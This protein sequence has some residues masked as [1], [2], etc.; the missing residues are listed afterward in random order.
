MV[1]EITGELPWLNFVEDGNFLH[2]SF[3]LNIF[4]PYV[5][6]SNSN[7]MCHVYDHCKC[8]VKN[9]QQ[10]LTD[11]SYRIFSNWGLQL[12]IQKKFFPH[13]PFE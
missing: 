13:Q 10:I 5:Q 9:K 1:F 7:C 2:V 3:L 4:N 11:V 12:L 8:S 6:H